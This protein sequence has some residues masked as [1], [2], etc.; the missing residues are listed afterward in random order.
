MRNR[1]QE[2]NMAMA[3]S[4]YDFQILK[5]SLPQDDINQEIELLKLEGIQN[6]SRDVI[7]KQHESQARSFLVD[8]FNYHP[9]SIPL[10]SEQEHSASGRLD[11]IERLVEWAAKQSDEIQQA[12]YAF[13]EDPTPGNYRIIFRLLQKTGLLHN[14]SASLAPRKEKKLTMAEMIRRAL[15]L[16]ERSKDELYQLARQNLITKRPEATVRQ[17]LRRMLKANEILETIPDTF[18]YIGEK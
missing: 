9:S 14:Q 3:N 15:R 12:L 7:R 11:A 18:T 2:N 13:L 1:N 8:D 6:P 16:Q 4:Q 10:F 17:T 5:P